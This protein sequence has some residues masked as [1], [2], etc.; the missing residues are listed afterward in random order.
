MNR[1]FVN[2]KQQGGGACN[3]KGFSVARLMGQKPRGPLRG[4]GL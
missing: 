2:M 4:G 3:Q 1:P